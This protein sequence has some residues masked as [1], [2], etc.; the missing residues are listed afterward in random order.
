MGLRTEPFTKLFLCLRC[1][2]LLVS[3]MGISILPGTYCC[4]HLDLDANPS[5]IWEPGDF[6][7]G[8]EGEEAR[9]F[10]KTAL[11]QQDSQDNNR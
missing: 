6:M 7:G 5:W 11:K 1:W 9:E 4:K 3:G 2:C 10:E 8:G